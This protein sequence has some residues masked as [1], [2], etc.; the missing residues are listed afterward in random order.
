[1][2]DREGDSRRKGL[3]REVVWVLAGLAAAFFLAAGIGC[4]S[5]KTPS[6]DAIAT[7]NGVEITVKDFTVKLRNALNLL[8]STSGLKE[9]DIVSAV[10]KDRP[11]FDCRTGPR[12]RKLLALTDRRPDR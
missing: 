11:F 2:E 9:E 7:V 1:M 8:G 6:E 5:F 12:R 3:R 10:L 4:S